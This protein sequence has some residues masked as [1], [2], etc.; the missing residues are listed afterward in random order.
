MVLTRSQYENLIK[1][2]LIQELTNIFSSFV[3]N[4]DATLTDLS[5]RF[6]DFT[7]KYDKVYSE[8]QQCKSYK[9]HLLTRIIQL[10]RNAVTNSQYSRRETIEINPV[11]AEIHEDAL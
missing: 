2:E 1:E 4:I 7:S 10:E 8:L 5:D 6:N 11:P 9:S 3:N